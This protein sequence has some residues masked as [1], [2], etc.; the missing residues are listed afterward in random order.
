MCAGI[1][2]CVW[3]GC[4][5]KFEKGEKPIKGRSSQKRGA[6]N[7]LPT[8]QGKVRNLLQSPR[9]NFNFREFKQINSLLRK[10]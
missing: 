7:P 8:M 9:E 2:V 6:R 3:G 10:Y 1:C 4:W 5:S